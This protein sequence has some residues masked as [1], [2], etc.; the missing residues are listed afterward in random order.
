M[1]ETRDWEKIRGGRERDERERGG[2]RQREIERDR[3]TDRKRTSK[4]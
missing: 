1:K 3:Q 2:G 4:K